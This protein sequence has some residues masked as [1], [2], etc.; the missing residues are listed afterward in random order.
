M[1]PYDAATQAHPGD[2]GFPADGTEQLAPVSGIRVL[3][4][5]GTVWP[6]RMH[7]R[8]PTL[9]LCEQCSGGRRGPPRLDWLGWLG[10]V[11]DQTG[12]VRSW[13]L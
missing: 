2:A 3:V 11:S 6:G 10:W 13:I 1:Q 9:P 12:G 5:F 4:V 8:G 7:P